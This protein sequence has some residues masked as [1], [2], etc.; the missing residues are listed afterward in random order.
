MERGPRGEDAIVTRTNPMLE[1]TLHE[2]TQGR[3]FDLLPDPTQAQIRALTPDELREAVRHALTRPMPVAEGARAREAA[4]VLMNPC[5]AAQ[6][7]ESF[8]VLALPRALRVFEP[9][10]GSS[11]PVVLAAEVHSDGAGEYATLNL[12]CPLAG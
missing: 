10:A 3:V 1:R 11:E 7:L 2:V 8:E 12:N 5:L 6:W 9:C 4:R